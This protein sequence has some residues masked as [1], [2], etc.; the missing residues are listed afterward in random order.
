MR[1]H[2]ETVL[3]RKSSPI[4]NYLLTLKLLLEIKYKIQK[5]YTNKLNT[6]CQITNTW[7]IHSSKL[8]T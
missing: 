3:I 8:A 4:T 6:A 7:D 2:H 1:I 5:N